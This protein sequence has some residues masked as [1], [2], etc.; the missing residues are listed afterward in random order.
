MLE[1]RLQASIK[2]ALESLGCL[3][4]KV[5]P[6]PVGVPDLLVVYTP[7]KH[8]WLEVKTPTGRLSKP[9]IAYHKLLALRNEPVSVVRTKDEALSVYKQF[10]QLS[11]ESCVVNH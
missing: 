3:V 4:F 11:K 10:T 1:S 7:G 8:F 5:D 2:R 6:P 9:Q